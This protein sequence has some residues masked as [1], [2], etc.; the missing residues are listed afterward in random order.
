MLSVTPKGLVA[1]LQWYCANSVLETWTKH[2]LGLKPIPVGENRPVKTGDTHKLVVL[3]IKVQGH[4]VI[5]PFCNINPPLS[6][7]QCNV[8]QVLNADWILSIKV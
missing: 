2:L 3:I 5:W 1:L 7:E 4:K 6:S 8:Y